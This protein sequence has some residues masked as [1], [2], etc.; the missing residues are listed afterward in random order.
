MKQTEEKGIERVLDFL[1][2]IGASNKYAHRPKLV[3]TGGEMTWPNIK[4]RHDVSI[5]E[6]L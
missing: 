2:T 1:N 5:K 4:L 3:N 6:L